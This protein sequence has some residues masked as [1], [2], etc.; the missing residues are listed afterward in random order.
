[1]KTKYL[2]YSTLA[3]SCLVLSCDDNAASNQ[4]ISCPEGQTPNANTGQC[5]LPHTCKTNDDCSNAQICVENKCTTKPDGCTVDTECPNDQRCI[6]GECKEIKEAECS[7]DD[8]CKD[9]KICRD[10]QCIIECSK[11][12]DCTEQRICRDNRCTVECTNN[13]DCSDGLVCRSNVCVP[14][15]KTNDDCTEERI[16]ISNHCSY[17]CESDDNCEDDLVCRNHH[18][19]PECQN[20]T[21]CKETEVCVEQKC[22]AA[23]TTSD[24]CANSFICNEGLCEKDP[25]WC[26]TDDECDSNFYCSKNHCKDPSIECYEDKDCNGVKICKSNK[27]ALECVEHA[28]CED[29]FVCRANRCKPECLSNSDCTL[30]SYCSGSKC[31]KDCETNDNCIS[32]Y[33]CK[34]G[35][36]AA[37]CTNTSDCTDG[38]LCSNMK[39][40][41]CI[42]DTDC[43]GTDMVCHMNK[44]ENSQIVRYPCLIE[45]DTFHIYKTNEGYNAAQN[46]DGSINLCKL[47]YYPSLSEIA[48]DPSK[49]TC[50]PLYTARA[51]DFYGDGVDSNCDGYDYNLSDAIFVSKNVQG[52]LG[53][54]DSKSGKYNP[55]S[56][57]IEP[58][59]TIS[60]ALQLSAT[61]YQISP[62][63]VSIYPDILVA[64]DVSESIS[65]PIVL[66]LLS[67]HSPADLPDL[68]VISDNP[69]K[70]AYTE[71]SVLVK[72]ILEQT[73]NTIANY[74]FFT[75]GNY[76]TELIRIF[77]GFTQTP[78]DDDNYLHWQHLEDHNSKQHL[79][80]P[81]ID[82]DSYVMV[83][84]D[85]AS[86][87]SFALSDFE[88]SMSSEATSLPHGTTFIGLSCGSAGCSS[89]NLNRTKWTITA[90]N[91]VSRTTALDNGTGGDNGKPGFV[92]TNG[93]TS[94]YTENTW[95]I[96]SQVCAN[97]YTAGT[98]GCGGHIAKTND[99]D[100]E[101]SANYDGSGNA[102]QG[103]NGTNGQNIL[104]DGSVAATGGTG[105]KGLTDAG[106]IYTGCD[107]NKSVNPD[108]GHGYDGNN[109][110]NG[111]NGTHTYLKMVLK[112]ASD[113]STMY[114]ASNYD[115]SSDI[116]G[117]D[118]AP[119]GGG[120]VVIAGE[121]HR[122][123]I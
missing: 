69:T 9:N 23:C 98:G 117:T 88:M 77:G 108:K 80:I 39:C 78:K 32:P 12:D 110:S 76:P 63:A 43:N 19:G 66:K 70:T 48:A 114:F 59:S 16:C 42:Q 35:Q 109:G 115:T 65:S 26:I 53:G 46:T 95:C 47:G 5:E 106:I 33:I 107:S 38:K 34:L 121:I 60:G 50:L 103:K 83:S 30:P 101:K 123:V 89:L 96:E 82:S 116:K 17:E 14:E 41:E 49:D 40:V 113:H 112:P 31:I 6:R 61:T 74:K 68:L 2:I 75:E 27:C 87:V 10:N 11:N 62:N 15:C 20:S 18:C 4:H 93:D 104:L 36:C 24:D 56:H 92:N 111:R 73:S 72:E 79:V 55:S 21:D 71:H 119:G 44:C 45:G 37:E 3:L 100:G 54:S 52:E 91:G 102:Y 81:S 25:S 29:G 99:K 97:D 86:S 51:Y 7:Q 13:D 118:G 105:G 120:G 84:S 85:G 67:T 57:L 58:K 94:T 90:P 1:M 28:N 122:R 8:D 64:K 22:I